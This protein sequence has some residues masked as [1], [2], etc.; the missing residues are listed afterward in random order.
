M[1]FTLPNTIYFYYL[2]KDFYNKAYD[3]D[4]PSRGELPPKGKK[5]ENNNEEAK[6]LL[7]QESTSLKAKCD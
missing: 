5:Q 4:E 7:S 1:I 2:F 3:S 6:A